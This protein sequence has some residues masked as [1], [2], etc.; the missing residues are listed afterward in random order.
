MNRLSGAVFLG[1]LLAA[2]SGGNGTSGSSGTNTTSGTTAG[3]GST[4]SGGTG[5]TTGGPVTSG[6]PTV[7]GCGIDG[8]YVSSFQTNHGPGSGRTEVDPDGGFLQQVT[9]GQTADGGAVDAGSVTTYLAGS[10]SLSGDQV[11]LLNYSGYAS[12]GVTIDY[13]P[14]VTGVY[15]MSYSPDC[16]TL[17]LTMVSDSCQERIHEGNGT[18][19]HRQ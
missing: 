17:T 16:N 15:T 9:L 1:L 12:N 7:N 4:S 10:W 18:P 13:C 5:S 2:C 6:N 8:V 14:G 3:S 19:L 11:S